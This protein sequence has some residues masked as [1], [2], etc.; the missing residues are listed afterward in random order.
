MRWARESGTGKS[1]L[2]FAV[3]EAGAEATEAGAEVAARSAP[4]IKRQAD[5]AARKKR[6]PEPWFSFVSIR[7]PCLEGIFP[8]QLQYILHEAGFKSD[9]LL[10]GRFFQ[11]SE[12]DRGFLDLSFD[13]QSEVEIKF[14]ERGGGFCRVFHRGSAG[15][16]AIG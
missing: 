11:Q 2:D 16:G 7:L 4:G 6:L 14:F 8:I 13:D 9:F 12:L 15:S 3:A 5:N 10:G 1:A